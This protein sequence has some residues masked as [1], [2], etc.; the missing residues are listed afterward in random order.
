MSLPP[1]PAYNDVVPRLPRIGSETPQPGR[2]RDG[3]QSDTRPN[4]TS[5]LKPRVAVLLGVDRQWHLPLILT[6][7]C[8]TAPGAYWSLR[9]LW[10]LFWGIMDELYDANPRG[11]EADFEHLKLLVELFLAALWV[12]DALSHGC[13]AA[14]TRGRALLQLIWH[15]SSQTR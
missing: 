7:A 10:V 11:R 13:G 14:L 2:A 4:T 12:C 8:S 15:T 9:C 3:S 1:P 5:A 6:R